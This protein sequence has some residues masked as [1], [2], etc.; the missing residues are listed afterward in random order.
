M[1]L[2]CKKTGARGENLTI[3]PGDHK[4]SQMEIEPEPHW[5]ETSALSTDS[6]RSLGFGF[7]KT[8]ITKNTSYSVITDPYTLTSRRQ[9]VSRGFGLPVWGVFVSLLFFWWDFVFILF[10]FFFK[11]RRKGKKLAYTCNSKTHIRDRCV[12]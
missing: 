11:K 6:E 1:V 7:S 8:F 5:R 2:L 9:L 10:S 12:I 4:S 3:R